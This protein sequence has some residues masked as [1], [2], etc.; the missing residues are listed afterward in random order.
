MTNLRVQLLVMGHCA[1]VVPAQ[2]TD[3]KGICADENRSSAHLCSITVVTILK[4][5]SV[6]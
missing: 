2:L 4:S 5:V 6:N 3:H 1:V